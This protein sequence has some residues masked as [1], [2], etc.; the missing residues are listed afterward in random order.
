M[1]IKLRHILVAVAVLALAGTGLAQGG[2]GGPGGAGGGQ[3]RGMRGMGGMRMNPFSLL[4]VK[5]VQDELKITADQKTKIEALQT[6]YREAQRKAFQD[7]RDSGSTDQ[8]AMMK[9]SQKLTDDTTKKLNA[10]LSAEQQK[11]LKELRV[12][13]AGNMALLQPDLQKELEFTTKQKDD[14]KALQQKLMQ[15][16]MDVR[17]KV[18]NQELTQEEAQKLYTKNNETMGAELLKLLTTD[19]ATKFKAMSGA[20]F[21][22]PK[23]MPGMGGMGGP[24]GRRNGGGAGGGG[25]TRGGGGG[26]GG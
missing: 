7:A 11:R 23:D 8:D 20:A 3:G 19:Q 15:A 18:Q 13:Q 26:A 22:F 16:M 9:A 21:K 5:E 14:A 10:I 1:G 2:P 4:N 12:Q 25:G 6:E 17:Q 24:G